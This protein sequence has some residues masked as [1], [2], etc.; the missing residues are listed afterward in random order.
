MKFVAIKNKGA[1]SR[2]CLELIGLGFDKDNPKEAIGRF[3]S[4][5]KAATVLSLRLGIKVYAASTGEDDSFILNFDTFKEVFKNGNKQKMV[6]RVRYNY[7]NGRVF[8]PDWT[9]D[10]FSDWQG[11][12]ICEK[13]KAYP[14]L[15][16]Y[17]ANARDE[18][19]GYSIEFDVEK[20]NPAPLGYTIIYI[21]Q[22]EEVLSVLKG[23][24]D[25][26][27]K[28]MGA[29]PI[30]IIPDVG[31]IYSGS[32]GEARFF[33][34][35]YLV[36][37]NPCT[38][39]PFFDYDIYDQ[40]IFSENRGIKNRLEYF[41]KT[42]R[43]I[44][45]IKDRSLIKVILLHCIA[46]SDAYERSFLCEADL[47]P[48]DFKNFCLKFWEEGPEYGKTAV[49]ASGN[50]DYD[51][52]AEYIGYKVIS[53]VDGRL[54]EIFKK[55]GVPDMEQII[56]DRNSKIKFRRFSE[57]EKKK[58]RDACRLFFRFKYYKENLE[59]V[60]LGVFA[61]STAAAPKKFYGITEDFLK[62]YFNE[63]L[64]D[65]TIKGEDDFEVPR[66]L[67]H[68]IIHCVSRAADLTSEFQGTAD[69]ISFMNLWYANEALDAL[70]GEGI[71]LSEVCGEF[72]DDEEEPDFTEVEESD[73]EE[74]E[75]EFDDE[76]TLED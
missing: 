52:Y 68:E 29:K 37:A 62:I 58:V 10:A 20:I 36:A 45:A 44:M 16:E 48:D 41:K 70:E 69:R 8:I 59:K 67:L 50:S 17:V 65:G 74:L 42:G 73:Y 51:R 61:D 47:M 11:A 7:D 9:V 66:T 4:G 53:F 5:F 23:S 22:T 40:D 24:K 54:S 27:F 60:L 57:E 13:N 15:R 30:V 28:F 32:P 14:I 6:S 38:S 43:L 46:N 19:A 49:L 55:A 1:V 56:K 21:E 63:K 71:K 31:A 33:A 12:L 18:D 64:L 2:R 39:K 3:K 26:Y 75:N 35:G 25:R 34:C 76:D 72:V